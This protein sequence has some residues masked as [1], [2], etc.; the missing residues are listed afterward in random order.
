M[1]RWKRVA[2]VAV[3]ASLAVGLSACAAGDDSGDSANSTL[4][5]GL[6]GP[7][8]TM[9]AADS[10]WANESPYHQAVFDTILRAEP[11]GTIVEGLATSW[12]YNED[13]TVLT[14]TIRDGVTFTDGTALDADAVA[15][16]IIRFRDGNS[17]DKTRIKDIADAVAT[18]AST[19]TVTLSEPNPAILTYLSQDAGLVESPAAFTN[20]DLKTNPIGSG[21]YILDVDKTVIGTSYVYTSNPD[22][23]DADSRHYDNLTLNVYTDSTALVNALKGGQVNAS[24]TADNNDIK[25]IE[26][27]G[28]TATPLELNW[29]GILLLDRDG[30]IAPAL[31]DV[32]VRQAINYAFDKEALLKAIGQGY[33][34]PTTQIFPENSEAYDPSLDSAYDYDP[35]K[36]K[37]LLA[38]AGYPNG[39]ELSMPSTAL[40]G[41]SAFTLIQQQLAD[42]GITVTYTDTGNNFLS[43]VIAAKYPASYLYLQQDP[44]W[45]LINF[46]I[47]PDSTFNMF[48]N[49]DPTI[50]GLIE[51]IHT[52]SG[53]EYNTAVKALNTYIVEQAWFA[54]WYRQQIN[55]VTDANTTV[56]VQQ[57]NAYP[58]L[59]NI[60]P[61]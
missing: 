42:V 31:A 44:D 41:T 23:W 15:Q 36:A 5:L 2:A 25:E 10:Y 34:T 24:T 7:A 49:E 59:W 30:T 6:L 39:F 20:A 17:P 54:P 27:S 52:T 9:V 12:E 29:A 48:K 60:Q 14:L 32:K 4:T 38:E 18:D 40:L 53:E 56:E 26:A 50:A 51:T 55:F 35:K 3:A 13:N 16:N 58:Y 8:T 37:N 46:E 28:F 21:P 19:V 47:A 43:D 57:G 33:G 11:D 22:Y 1:F 45:A 61:K